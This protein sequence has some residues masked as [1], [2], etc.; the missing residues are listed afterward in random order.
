[1]EDS[2]G[3]KRYRTVTRVD[4]VQERLGSVIV[5][6]RTDDMVPPCTPRTSYR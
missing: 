2:V 5:Q 4:L 3:R 1:M 6:A